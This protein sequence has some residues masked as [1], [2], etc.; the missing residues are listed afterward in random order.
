MIPLLGTPK[1]ML[2][3]ALEMG[4]CS[5]GGPI[6]GYMGGLSFLRAFERRV[7]FLFIRRTFMRNSRYT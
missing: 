4:I 7:K 2:S 3:K 1:D 5:H 6:L